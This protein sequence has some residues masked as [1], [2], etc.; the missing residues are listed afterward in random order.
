MVFKIIRTLSDSGPFAIPSCTSGGRRGRTFCSRNLRE[1]RWLLFAY[2]ERAIGD[3]PDARLL[4]P[5]R[6]KLYHMGGL[7]AL[8]ET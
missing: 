3:I 6:T 2:L 7:K 8:G 1:R 4:G 5:G